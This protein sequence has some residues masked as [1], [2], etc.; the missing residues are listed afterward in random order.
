MYD[1]KVGM[2][3]VVMP[4]IDVGRRSG[5]ECVIDACIVEVG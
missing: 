2:T 3:Q 5:D 4:D 1:L